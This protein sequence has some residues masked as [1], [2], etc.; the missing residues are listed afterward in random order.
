MTRDEIVATTYPLPLRPGDP[1]LHLRAVIRYP[2]PVITWRDDGTFGWGP[3]PP[4]AAFHGPDELEDLRRSLTNHEEWRV[5]HQYLVD[6]GCLQGPDIELR[7]RLHVMNLEAL[8]RAIPM[9][10]AGWRIC[11]FDV[12]VAVL[13][14]PEGYKPWWE[15]QA[16]KHLLIPKPDRWPYRD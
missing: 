15:L 1:E 2:D 16:N 6:K 12:F 13:V 11:G 7:E 5:E 14:R 4:Q 3:L 10:E 9:A 8:E